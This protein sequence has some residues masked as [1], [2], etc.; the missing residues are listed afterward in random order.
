MVFFFVESMCTEI[1][2][3]DRL[4]KYILALLFFCHFFYNLQVQVL[5]LSDHK[6]KFLIDFN[7]TIDFVDKNIA[8]VE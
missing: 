2:K 8:R 3:R 4:N 1:S 6:M 5:F 7:L